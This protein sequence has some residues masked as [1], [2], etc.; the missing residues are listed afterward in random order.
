MLS[1][2]L[3]LLAA[4]AAAQALNKRQSLNQSIPATA[5][6][7][8]T[9]VENP[10]ALAS[11]FVLNVEDLWDLLVGPVSSAA[12]TT[13]VSATAVPS[14][15]LIPP[16]PL[17]YS[18][19]PSGQQYPMEPKNESWSFPKDFWWGVAGAAY[20]IEGAA[21]AEGRGPSVWDVL[22]H[23]VT[24]FVVNNYT[25]DV[26]DNFY[27]YYKEGRCCSESKTKRSVS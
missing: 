16:P 14:S 11:S 17:Y 21:K 22:T 20:Q 24:D 27:Y 15:S 5:T 3:L 23:R 4:A 25:A 2:S 8:G 1:C 18:P 6:F 9:A 19:F 7:D 12:I 10:T 26:T 13:T